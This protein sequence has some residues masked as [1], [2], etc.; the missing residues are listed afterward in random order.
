[1]AGTSVFEVT[2]DNFQ[3]DVLERSRQVP[4]LLDFWAEWCGPCKTL[5]PLLEKL[6]EEY[7]GAFLLGKIDSDKEQDL[8]YAF[9]V[10]SIPFV[11]LLR[12]GRP[13]DAFTGLL[14]E[15]ELRAFL[16]KNKITAAAPK[17]DA[18]AKLDPNSPEALIAEA[19]KA[20]LAL[21]PAKAQAALAKIPADSPVDDVKERLTNGLGWFA[22]SH[23]KSPA[24]AAKALLAARAAF[25]A[26][27]LDA[28]MEALLDSVASDR[29]YADG[30][31]RKAML[32]CLEL[33]S[34]DDDAAESYRRRLATALY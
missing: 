7:G 6:A 9:Q 17:A 33:H 10:S 19:K 16:T 2:V 26:G 22:A 14:Q 23:E 11:V 30:I 24:P 31:A 18:P 13:A 34:G 28:A 29:A 32:V 15:R 8:A 4:I 3:A 20:L 21:D 1:M 5:A 27:R 12:N 25:G